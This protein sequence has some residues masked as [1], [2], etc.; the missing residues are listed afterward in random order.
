VTPPVIVVQID[1]VCQY[2][3]NLQ[4]R[5]LVSPAAEGLMGPGHYVKYSPDAAAHTK[6][7][8][9]N[10]DLFDPVCVV[11][12]VQAADIIASL[13]AELKAQEKTNNVP[14]DEITF[15]LDRTFQAGVDLPIPRLSD[16]KLKA[17]PKATEVQEPETFS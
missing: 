15:K 13:V 3:E 1:P 4:L 8:F 9:S 16:L 14:F 10:G 7:P 2:V 11:P 6:A 17:G 5:C 12:G